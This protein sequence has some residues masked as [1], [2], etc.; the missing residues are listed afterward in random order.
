MKMSGRVESVS[1]CAASVSV[2]NRQ[3]KQP[4]VISSVE[5][6]RHGSN[7]SRLPRA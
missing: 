2:L 4:P 6:Q 1:F 5:N 3:Q 7:G